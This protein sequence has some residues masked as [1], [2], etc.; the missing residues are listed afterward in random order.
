MDE[1]VSRREFAADLPGMTQF[2]KARCL[3]IAERGFS[4]WV[5]TPIRNEYER[6]LLTGWSLLTPEQRAKAI[7]ATYT[8]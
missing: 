7:E 3:L 6:I 4:R 8:K 2:Q 5:N 1:A